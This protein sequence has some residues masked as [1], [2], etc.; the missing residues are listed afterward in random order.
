MCMTHHKEQHT[1]WKM[2]ASFSSIF[3]P[4]PAGILSSQLDLLLYNNHIPYLIF[5]LFLQNA[6]KHVGKVYVSCNIF[7]SLF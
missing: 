6:R 2:S 7:L 3:S 4:Y 1:V 5:S